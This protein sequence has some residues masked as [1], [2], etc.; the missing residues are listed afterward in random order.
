MAYSSLLTFGRSVVITHA[1]AAFLGCPVDSG[2]LVCMDVSAEISSSSDG[3]RQ[4]SPEAEAAGPA[5][6]PS[7]S[8]SPSHR[9]RVA[10]AGGGIA[11]LETLLA[12]SQLAGERVE[13]TLIAPE[14]EFA[15]RPLS[16]RE[17]FAYAPARRYPL[18]RIAAD[19]G[20][21]LLAGELGWVDPGR[22]TLHTAD[23]RA[24]EYDALMLA[25]GARARERYKHALTIDDCRLDETLHGLIQDVEQ[26][27]VTRVALVAP[28][29][30]AWPLP[31]Y[32]LAL[33]TSA[34][35]YDMGVD[36]A[37]T[38]VTPEDAPLAIFGSAAS[39]AVAELLERSHVETIGSAY[40][41]V[42]SAGRVTINPGDRHLTADRVI[43]LPELYGPGV[44]GIPLSEHGFI[45]VD[46]FGHVAGVHDVYAAGDATDFAIK[47]GG[48]ASQQADA[49]ARSIAAVAGAPVEPEP[50]APVIRGMLL[51]GGA[52]L[53]LTARIT[54]GHG[55]S[56]EIADAPTWSPPS[57]VAS[58]YLAPY[59]DGLDHG[60][61][62]AGGRPVVASSG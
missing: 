50:F 62:T 26:G 15:Y 5:P 61:R 13:L 12:L 52:P 28:G 30:M 58:R 18:A 4:A 20:A 16:V 29:R 40:A 38:I 43:A 49:A 33:M 46:P 21:R 7:D 27:Y 42:P 57:K 59:L 41:E 39:T 22:H 36:L 14:D 35:A 2:D 34:R 32:E 45:R 23:G 1:K 60:A 47:H 9:L 48:I 55:F 17:P 8:L 24:V 31:L 54:G 10:I 6:A 11:G 44:R 3:R 37:T 56:S 25:V 51:T 53:Y 19:A